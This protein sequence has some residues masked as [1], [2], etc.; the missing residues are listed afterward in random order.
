MQPT[1]FLLPILALGA[2]TLG[3][4]CGGGGDSDDSA[5][6]GSTVKTEQS[7][8][9]TPAGAIT[10]K[11]KEFSFDPEV[12]ELKAGKAATIVLENVGA[13]EHDITVD[14]PALKIAAAPTKTAKGTLKI[15]SPGEYDFYCSVPGHRASGMEGTVRVS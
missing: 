5:D 10:V 8:N 7:G 1:R 2:L 14:D 13:I 15:S 11:A 6:S 9:V 12:I 4:A 3:A